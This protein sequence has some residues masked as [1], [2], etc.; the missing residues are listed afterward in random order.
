MSFFG[1]HRSNVGCNTVLGRR[2]FASHSTVGSQSL[3]IL[4]SV[5]FHSVEPLAHQSLEQDILLVG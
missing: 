2:D 3:R 5:F 1:H 4:E